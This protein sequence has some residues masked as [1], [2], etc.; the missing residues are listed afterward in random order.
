MNSS[1]AL[2]AYSSHNLNVSMKTSSGDVI[3]L[4]FTNKKSLSMQSNNSNDS[5]SSSMKFSSMRS[6]EFHIETNGID[7]QDAKEI[8]EFMKIAQPKIDSFLKELQDEAPKSPVTKLA[9]DITSIFEPS[10]LRDENNK[11]FVKKNIVDMFDNSLEE[12]Q[13]PEPKQ[14]DI[15]K[16]V[17]KLLEQTLKEFEDFNKKLYA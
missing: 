1:Y 11:D 3:N 16:E 17:Q 10:K 14:H 5:S 13:I 15:F 9:K 2:D 8:K 4:D 6:F 12:A 7:E